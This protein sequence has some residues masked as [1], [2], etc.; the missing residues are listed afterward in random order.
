MKNITRRQFFATTVVAVLLATSHITPVRPQILQ[1]SGAA[2]SQAPVDPWAAIDGRLNA[3][4]I[5]TGPQFPNALNGYGPGG[6]R[7][8][9]ST[10][11]Q[12]PWYVAGVDYPTGINDSAKPLKNGFS[13]SL[14]SG[15]SRSGSQIT[16]SGNNVTLDGYDFSFNSGCYIIVNGNNCTIQNCLFKWGTNY[17]NNTAILQNGSGLLVRYCEFD[18]LKNSNATQCIQLANASGSGTILYCWL[19]DWND[20]FIRLQNE[21][22]TSGVKNVQWYVRYNT[23]TNGGWSGVHFDCC[24]TVNASFNFIDWSFNFQMQDWTTGCGAATGFRNSDFNSPSGIAGSASTVAY[25]TIIGT[26]N[27]TTH[28]T[29]DEAIVFS[30]TNVGQLNNPICHDCYFDLS[31]LQSTNL[32][33]Y[34]ADFVINGVQYNCWDM[35]RVLTPNANNPAGYITARQI[36]GVSYTNYTRPTAPTF[37]GATKSGSAIAITGTC[38]ARPSGGKSTGN[39]MVNVFV[40]ELAAPNNLIGTQSVAP[41]G[42]ISLTT[43]SLAAGTYTVSICVVDDEWNA[44]PFTATRTVTI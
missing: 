40:A 16:V 13:A 18:G 36:G 10:T 7:N 15:A 33:F 4:I 2:T 9:N 5:S 3:P 20:D 28:V 23:M 44:S 8:Y 22:A 11:Y 34:T 24:Q 32:V 35:A 6:V 17:G 21:P 37:S 1:F 19:H 29:L 38:P 26:G 27:G 14:P 25:C 31:G 42:A 30:G 12:P 43:S 41:G 39:Y